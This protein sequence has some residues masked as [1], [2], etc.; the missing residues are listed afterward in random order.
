LLVGLPLV[1]FLPT[2]LA[3]RALFTRKKAV[4]A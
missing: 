1:V 4:G 2:H 3:L